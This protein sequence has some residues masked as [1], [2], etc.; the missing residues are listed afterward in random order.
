M[1]KIKQTL[2]LTA[3]LPMLGL[4]S[5]QAQTSTLSF[6]LQPALFNSNPTPR[7]FG[8]ES[9][10]YVDFTSAL[11]LGNGSATNQRTSPITV[12]TSTGDV[13]FQLGSVAGL[14]QSLT[15]NGVSWS[16][17]TDGSV[18]NN[19]AESYTNNDG[20]N[21][22]FESGMVT[23][24]VG[25][26]GGSIDISLT[27]LTV[28]TDYRLQLLHFQ[29]GVAPSGRQMILQNADDTANNSGVYSYFD[30]SGVFRAANMTVSFTAASSD[31][32]LNLLADPDGGAF[33]RSL[34]NGVALHAVPEPANFAAIFGALALFGV[35]L[36]RRRFRK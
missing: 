25:L 9:E 33:N 6:E 13:T 17:T 1:K 10:P 16:V 18:N 3:A 11:A 5:A 27:G 32:N 22:L 8:D 12:P 2:L 20:L 35:C 31:L 36:R 24:R 4:F 30:D 26:G 23:E 34:L 29:P 15:Q 21:T 7:V 19:F 14:T 28:G